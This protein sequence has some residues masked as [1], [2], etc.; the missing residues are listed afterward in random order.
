MRFA[1]DA[2]Q[3]VRRFVDYLR[4]GK[5]AARRKDHDACWNHFDN[6]EVMFEGIY[7]RLTMHERR[8]NAEKD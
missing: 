5:A 6:A 4:E 8:A 7:M 3:D 1:E 2:P